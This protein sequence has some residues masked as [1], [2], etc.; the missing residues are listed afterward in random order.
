MLLS[1]LR[2]AATTQMTYFTT[3]CHIEV[4]QTGVSD[5]TIVEVWAWRRPGPLVCPPTLY[6]RDLK[7][8]QSRWCRISGRSWASSTPA[9]I[10]SGTSSWAIGFTDR[11][12]FILHGPP[13]SGIR[14]RTRLHHLSCS[15][16]KYGRACRVCN[17]LGRCHRF[18]N[19][20]QLQCQRR[21]RVRAVSG[22]V[23][24]FA[25]T[26]ARFSFY[27]KQKKSPCR[28]NVSIF[29]DSGYTQE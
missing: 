3:C 13:D 11:S 20:H 15:C 21:Y 26:V 4:L 23:T 10:Q 22:D 6:V 8:K 24:D 5:L 2:W 19:K 7:R 9:Q 16:E 29:S 25:A 18:R 1:W 12:C 17:D 27:G 14:H 28:M